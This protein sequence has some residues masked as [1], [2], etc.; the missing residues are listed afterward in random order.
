MLPSIQVDVLQVR[1]PDAP[2]DTGAMDCEIDFQVTYMA[3]GQFV[4]QQVKES[5]DA[6]EALRAIIAINKSIPNRAATKGHLFSTV[7]RENV[8]DFNEVLV[9]FDGDKVLSKT[10]KFTFTG[11]FGEEGY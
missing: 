9:S 2:Q 1:Y 8:I 10:A 7:L 11:L 5:F 4:E 6:A 3:G